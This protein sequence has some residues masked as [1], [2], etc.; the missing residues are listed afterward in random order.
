VIR[1]R[2]WAGRATTAPHF[3]GVGLLKARDYT[4]PVLLQ[5]RG[6]TYCQLAY[7]I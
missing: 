1:E 2:F 3:A 5:P 4:S 6:F 7:E